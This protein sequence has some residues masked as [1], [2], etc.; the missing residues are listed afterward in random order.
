MRPNILTLC[1]L[2]LGGG[3]ASMDRAD[4]DTLI[5]RANAA[6]MAGDHAHALALFDSVN[7][8]WRS[9]GLSYAIGNCHFKMDQVPQAILHYERA[10][11]LEP[12]AADVRA[13]LEL[14][15]QR[16]MDRVNEL[17][18]FRLGDTWEGWLAG[19]D[20][21]QWAR[22]SLWAWCL[23]FAA[24]AF[25]LTKRGTVRTAGMAAAACLAL[26][27]AGSAALAARRVRA[28]EHGNG[29]IVLEPRVDVRSEP[30][31]GAT[32][33]FMLHAGTKVQVGAERDGWVEVTLA[34]GN[35]GCMPHP[36]LERI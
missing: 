23:G 34:N 5:A 7:T 11:L 3:A 21:D 10:L 12:G 30:R 15:R 31:D 2:L 29:A 16:T 35:V 19:R 25:A 27:G 24:A 32:T 1:S 17:P 18:A 26:V 28:L 4:G 36:A 14:A 6:Y 13:N 22:R 33:L 9:A 8:H 20:V